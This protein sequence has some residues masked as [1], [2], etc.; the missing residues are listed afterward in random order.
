[1]IGYS[2]SDFAGDLDDRHST[3]GILFSLSG[4]VISWCSKKENIVTLSTSEAEY[5]ALSHAT[6]EAIWIRKL[7]GEIE[8]NQE[9][10]VL[11]MEDNQLGSDC[12]CKEPCESRQD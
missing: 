3:S 1:M 12:N 8:N 11:I 5:V 6:Q 10:P 4:G 7:I 2:D 9:K